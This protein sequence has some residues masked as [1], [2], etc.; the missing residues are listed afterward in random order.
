MCHIMKLK[1][2]AIRIFTLV[3]F[4]VKFWIDCRK[5]WTHLRSSHQLRSNDLHPWARWKS[6]LLIKMQN[7]KTKYFEIQTTKFGREI[8]ES[9]AWRAFEWGSLAT[10]ILPRSLCYEFAVDRH[11]EWNDHRFAACMCHPRAHYITDMKLRCKQKLDPQRKTSTPRMH[12][13]GQ[14]GPAISRR[15]LIARAYLIFSS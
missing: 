7:P 13:C 1:T 8:P 4:F 15:F 9:V 2:L 3:L 11:Q 10:N 12:I 6:C 14:Q 5:N